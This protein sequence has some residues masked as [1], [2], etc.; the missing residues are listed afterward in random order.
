LHLASRD[1][2]DRLLSVTTCSS[3]YRG[4][5]LPR[6]TE[7]RRRLEEGKTAAWSSQMMEQRF[8]PGALSDA[9]LAWF[10][11]EQETSDPDTLLALGDL[12][13]HLD[14][15]DALPRISVPVL[16]IAADASPY[17]TV[18]IASAM[19]K[20][21]RKADLEIIP[22][23]RHGIPFSHADAC[24]QAFLNFARQQRFIPET[25]N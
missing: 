18:D 23:S 16:L 2:G 6:V 8:Y 15:S 22:H 1:T 5:D 17:V 13:L 3:P 14:L 21:I 11:K 25:D 10:A 9:A 4:S 20:L 24:A 12:L 19:K 7:W